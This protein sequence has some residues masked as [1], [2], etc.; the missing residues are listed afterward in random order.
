MH[1]YFIIYDIFINFLIQVFIKYFVF[2]KTKKVLKDL[3][4]L[5]RE[6]EKIVPK[7][8]RTNPLNIYNEYAK[9]FQNVDF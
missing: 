1:I 4:P 2:I 9:I 8:Q 6:L 7:K 3:L 5:I